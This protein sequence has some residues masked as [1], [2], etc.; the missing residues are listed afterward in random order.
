MHLQYKPNTNEGDFCINPLVENDENFI[1]KFSPVSGQADIYN[2]SVKGKYIVSNSDSYWRLRLGSKTN[3]DCQIHVGKQEDCT[4]TM[5]GVWMNNQFFNFD[6]IT[7]GSY[8]YSDKGKGAVW[9]IE[10]SSS[11]SSVSQLKEAEISVF[12]TFSKGTINVFSPANS[13]IKV[14]DISGQTLDI[15]R[16]SGSKMIK[17]DYPNGI[18]FICVS[19]DK[20]YVYKVIL[21]A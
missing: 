13:L 9:Q 16:S 19:A 8:V 1:F 11:E 2:I 14:I 4:F 21:Q 3:N 6:A 15:Y 20:R 5:K 17:L 10:K 7:P 12:P 18:Y